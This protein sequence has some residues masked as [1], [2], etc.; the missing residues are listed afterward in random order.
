HFSCSHASPSQNHHSR[1]PGRDDRALTEVEESQCGLALDR[2]A[3]VGPQRRIVTVRLVLLVG[4]IL[5]S[6]EIEQTV[7]GFGIGF[8]VALVALTTEPPPA[9]GARES[10]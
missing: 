2:G 6:L 7:D 4:E 1:E 10:K 8:G 5:D 9:I 3:F